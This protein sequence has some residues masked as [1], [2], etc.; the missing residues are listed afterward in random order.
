MVITRSTF[1][2]AGKDVGKWLGDNLSTWEQYRWQ[3][4]GMLDFASFFQM[5]M[6]SF[7]RL[8]HNCHNADCI[9]LCRLAQT[10]ADSAATPPKTYVPAGRPLEVSYPNRSTD[11]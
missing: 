4:Q 1:A 7:F 5:P 3:I 9:C 11:T 8:K 2:G 6:A 10:F